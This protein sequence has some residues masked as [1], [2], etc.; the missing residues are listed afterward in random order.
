LAAGD[1]FEEERT[2]ERL[3]MSAE[4][5]S[6]ASREAVAPAKNGTPEKRNGRS[7]LSERPFET[8]LDRK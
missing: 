4:L 6:Y 2:M 5:K 3:A 1:F 7:L 8:A